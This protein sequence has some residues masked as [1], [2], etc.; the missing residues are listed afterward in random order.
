MTQ[1]QANALNQIIEICNQNNLRIVDSNIDD[2]EL[3]PYSKET[4]EQYPQLLIT[5]LEEDD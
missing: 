3:P 4:L 5:P 1:A 2:L